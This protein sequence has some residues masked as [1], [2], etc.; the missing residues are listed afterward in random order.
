MHSFHTEPSL[1]RHLRTTHADLA[2]NSG[3]PA[4]KHA[5]ILGQGLLERDI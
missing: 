1:R 4:L 3:P 5:S 2:S